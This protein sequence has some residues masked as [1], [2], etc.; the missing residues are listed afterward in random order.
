MHSLC[1][2]H[3]VPSSPLSTTPLPR[4]PHTLPHN[5]R[6][7]FHVAW[8]I[9]L[10]TQLRS[11]Q[12]QIPRYHY[13]SYNSILTS[14]QLR[15]STDQ[16]HQLL[17]NL[18]QWSCLN[19]HPHCIHATQLSPV[20]LISLNDHTHAVQSIQ[21]RPAPRSACNKQPHSILATQLYNVELCINYVESTLTL[22]LPTKHPATT[23]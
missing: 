3:A 9:Q 2:L 20:Q 13:Q 12:R 5:T 21:L 14:V 11:G 15:S 6:L 16:S 4:H 19:D 18:A 8:Y 1:T 10:A 23:M 7:S 22:E 17:L